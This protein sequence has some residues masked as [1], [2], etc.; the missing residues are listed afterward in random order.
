MGRSFY[1]LGAAGWLMLAL[2]PACVAT[3]LDSESDV[4]GDDAL[5][6]YLTGIVAIDAQNSSNAASLLDGQTGANLTP[7]VSSN[8]YPS[9]NYPMRAVFD[10]G[11]VYDVSEVGLF[12]GNGSGLVNVKYLPV[13]GDATKDAGYTPIEAHVPSLWNAWETVKQTGTFR[14]RYVE[15]TI[16]SY[17]NF[18]AYSEIRVKGTAVAGPPPPPPPPPAS[19][20]TKVATGEYQSFF[21]VDGK[22]YALGI[23]QTLGIAGTSMGVPL[24]VVFPAGLKFNDVQSGLHQD[25]GRRSKTDTSGCGDERKRRRRPRHDRRQRDRNLQMI[26]WATP[27]VIRSTASSR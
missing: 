5:S 16:T 22:I 1:A 7:W 27:R 19:G 25:A 14:T 17:A 15:L 20:L 18:A 6:G 3:P 23:G 9:S 2:T 8:I 26:P 21:L 13:G 24:P 11:Q 4:S 10:L 12:H